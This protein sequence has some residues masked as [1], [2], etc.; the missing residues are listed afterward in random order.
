MVAVIDYDAGNIRSVEKA[1]VSLG[2]CVKVTRQ[3]QEILSANHII[4][5]GVGSFGDA[6][7][8]LHKY[9]LTDVI[10]E[11]VSRNIPLPPAVRRA[12]PRRPRRRAACCAKTR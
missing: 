6:M 4:L 7:G 3:R 8:K 1:I 5:P 9:G 11:A 10:R 2:G 12:G